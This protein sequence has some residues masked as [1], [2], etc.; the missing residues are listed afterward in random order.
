MLVL[1]PLV[2]AAAAPA[3]A[4]AGDS[5]AGFYYGMDGTGPTM[6]SCYPCQ[7]PT[8]GGT[9]GVYVAEIGG[10]PQAEGCGWSNA[11]NT[12]DFDDE[13]SNHQYG[14]WGDQSYFFLGGP[15]VD[16]N[17]NGSTTEA[18]NWGVKQGNQAIS[19]W[20]G[21][22]PLLSNASREDLYGDVE[23]DGNGLSTGWNSHGN[24]SGR[25]STASPG[26][27]LDRQTFNGFYNTVAGDGLVPALYSASDYWDAVLGSSY[28]SVPNT[29]E[30]TYQQDTSVQPAPVGFSAGSS[31]AI[32]FGTQTSS[33]SHAVMWQWSQAGGDWD[34][35]DTNHS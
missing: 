14:G 3:A 33:S 29:D 31:S 21:Q 13:Y 12:T 1:V 28:D 15:G 22:A 34:Q 17:Y 10:W 7:E 20:N 5:P 11:V 35:L 4:V 19:D 8:I 24:C 9:V 30:W 26:G 16:P 32:F 6:T 18:Y 2:F 25:T 27:A 23:P